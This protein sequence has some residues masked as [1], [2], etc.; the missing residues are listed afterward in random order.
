MGSIIYGSSFFSDEKG[1]NFYEYF[2]LK[3]TTKNTG[4]KLPLY[5]NDRSAV[6]KEYGQIQDTYKQLIDSAGW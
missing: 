2:Y 6:F 1:I 4:N 5:K 3:N